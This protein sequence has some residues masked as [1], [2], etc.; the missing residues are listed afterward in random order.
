MRH[1]FLEPLRRSSLLPFPFERPL[2]LDPE[3]ASSLS[4]RSSSD[5][6]REELCELLLLLEEE[7]FFWL[8]D[9]GDELDELEPV[10]AA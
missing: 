9:L 2:S 3:S 8:G 10:A 1:S 6:R 7:R 5:L 4:L